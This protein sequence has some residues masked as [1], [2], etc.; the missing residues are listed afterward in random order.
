MDTTTSIT[1]H[2]SWHLKAYIYCRAGVLVGEGMTNGSLSSHW[3]RLKFLSDFLLD[4]PSLLSNFEIKRFRSVENMVN[5]AYLVAI[6]Y[7]ISK[8]G[9][10]EQ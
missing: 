1:L 8:S 7:L 4:F 9:Y 10:V 3:R 5:L 2:L 6:S